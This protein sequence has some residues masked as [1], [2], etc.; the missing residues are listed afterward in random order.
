MAFNI[1]ATATSDI[2]LANLD[3]NFT[4]IGSSAVASTLYPTATTSITYGTT[5]TIHYFSGSGLAVTGTLS[6]TLDATLHGLTVGLGGGSFTAMTVVGYQAQNAV[7]TVG[8][9]TMVGYQAGYANTANNEAFGYRALYTNN[10]GS[11]NVAIGHSSLLL[12]TSGQFNIAIGRDSLQANTT[13]SNNTAVGYQAGYTN[14]T[15]AA[16]NYLG[17]QAGYTSNANYCT[18]MGDQAGYSSTGVGNTF[19]G[20]YAGGGVTSGTQNNCFGYASGNAITTGGKNSILGSYNGNQGGL[21]IRTASNYI[22]LSDGDGNPR[23]IFDSSGNLGLGV[24]P[25]AWYTGYKAFQLTGDIGFASIGGALRFNNYLNAGASAD[26]YYSNGWAGR[27]RFTLG[28]HIWDTAASGTAGNTITFTQAMTLDASGNL[29][30]GTTSASAGSGTTVSNANNST[31]AFRAQSTAATSPNSI[32]AKFTAASPNNAGNDFLYCEDGGSTLRA[33]IY[34]N[35]GLANY[36]ANNVNLSDKREK[37]NFASAKS[38]LDVICAIPVQTF[39]YIDQNLEEDD[40]FTLG[41]VAQDVQAVAPELV[42][43]SNW[44]SKD[45]EPKMRLSI[46]QTDLQYALMK[47]I[48]EQQAII[49]A[50]T[51]R[52]TAL[53]A[54]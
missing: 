44:A 11:N 35:G 4:M 3:A 41:V 47:C 46:Y 48:Q 13:A 37:T 17:R 33:R 5:G 9:A 19:F 50:L 10:T 20:Y 16:S 2:P 32:L 27:Y 51:T 53:E 15:G 31:W 7:N 25:S 52:I 38:Y 23:G 29:L 6:S 18:M 42:M 24:T 39:N 36:S 1:F 26:I 45:E 22:V 14:T 30:V 40:G 21:D 8:Y 49:T 34:S 54:K 28:N 12:N 43:E